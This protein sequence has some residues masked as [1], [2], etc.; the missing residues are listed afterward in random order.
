MS[1]VKPK[2]F[3][4]KFQDRVLGAVVL[5]AAGL[6]VFAFY[7][8]QIKD[9]AADSVLVVT[10]QLNTTYGIDTNASVTLSG[11]LIGHVSDVRLT[12]EAKVEV[13]LQLDGN[14]QAFYRQG[15]SVKINSQ[16][17]LDTVISG[18]GMIFVPALEGEALQSGDTIDVIEPKSFDDLVAEWEVEKLVGQVRGIVQNLEQI[19]SNFE[20]N[21]GELVQTLKNLNQFTAE[22]N[23]TTKSIPELLSQ[24]QGTLA[25]TQQT[26]A[27]IGGAAASVEPELVKTLQESQQLMAKIAQT[28]A[29][30]QPSVAQLPKLM[31][32]VENTSDGARKLLYSLDNHW[33]MGNKEQTELAPQLPVH[34]FD[35]TLYSQKQKN[36][37]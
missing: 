12:D 13:T 24:V 10:A 31:Q 37:N 7:I 28:T 30:T 23:K 3:E 2:P 4:S 17:G 16:L 27:Q 8:S 19:T 29:A 15:S 5:V 18:N 1:F 6:L 34:P 14:Y 9:K 33:L 22:L 11:V 20:A 25:Q 36:N 32:S 26:I 21:Q 35:D